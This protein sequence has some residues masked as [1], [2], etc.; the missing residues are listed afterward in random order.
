MPSPINLAA[1]SDL[2]LAINSQG[3]NRDDPTMMT[4]MTSHKTMENLPNFLVFNVSQKNN[5]H[6]LPLRLVS[7]NETF[8][9]LSSLSFL[10]FIRKKEVQ[11][12]GKKSSVDI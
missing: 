1:L 9:L 2:S 4:A 10:Y 12:G 8:L 7:S 6:S 3:G 11:E 5:F